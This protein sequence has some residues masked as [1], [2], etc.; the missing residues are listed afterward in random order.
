M[1]SYIFYTIR[2]KVKLKI[3]F[4]NMETEAGDTFPLRYSLFPHVPPY[5]REMIKFVLEEIHFVKTLFI[6]Y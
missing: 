6:F 3:F 1:I 5:I 4:R 2:E